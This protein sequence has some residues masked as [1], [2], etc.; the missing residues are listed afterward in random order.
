MCQEESYE[1][2]EM[3]GDIHANLL[4]IRIYRVYHCGGMM[5]GY[6]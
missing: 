6:M 3:L 5:K 4:L 2:V 1:H